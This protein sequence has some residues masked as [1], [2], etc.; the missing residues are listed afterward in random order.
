[1]ELLNEIVVLNQKYLK[2][3]PGAEIHPRGRWEVRIIFSE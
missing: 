3:C 2:R 1:M